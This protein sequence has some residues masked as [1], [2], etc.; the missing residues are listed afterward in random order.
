MPFPT[1]QQVASGSVDLNTILGSMVDRG[2]WPYYDTAYVALTT[3]TLSAAL[4]STYQFFT[5]PN[6]G[7]DPIFSAAKNFCQTNMIS[8]G[9]SNGF[10]ATRCFI[11]E[12]FGFRF[13]SFLNKAS[14]DSIIECANFT[15]QIAEKPFFQ[16]RLEDWPGGAGLM[17]VTTQ[18]GEETWTLGLPIPQAMRRFGLKFSKYIAPQIPFYFTV[19][20]PTAPTLTLTAAAPSGVGIVV[21]ST[22]CIPFMRVVLDGLTDRAVQ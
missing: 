16:G 15:F 22:T 18:T 8:S 17:G 9:S 4:N 2:I 10:G 20:F 21:G 5:V 13:P 3:S 1:M 12:S 6:A 14:V 11:L 7:V 19:S